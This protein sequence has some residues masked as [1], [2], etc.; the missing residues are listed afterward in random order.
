MDLAKLVNE[1]FELKPIR[2][3]LDAAGAAYDL[4]EQSIV[5]LEKLRNSGPDP[6]E[7]KQFVV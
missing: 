3:K 7:V 2:A 4:K 5:L 6:A 1:G